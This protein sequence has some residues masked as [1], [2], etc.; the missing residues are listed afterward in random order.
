MMQNVIAPIN[1]ERMADIFTGA[2]DNAAA[3]R[4]LNWYVEEQMA[5]A[6]KDGL[7]GTDAFLHSL[8]RILLATASAMSVASPAVKHSLPFAA[9]Y[10]QQNVDMI[11]SVWEHVRKQRIIAYNTVRFSDEEAE[12]MLVGIAAFVAQCAV[13]VRERTK[14]AA[15]DSTPKAWVVPA[16]A[17]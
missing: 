14:P 17:I 13:I 5:E 7:P 1:G 4:R 2:V 10:E 12:K 15:S 6:T 8:T 11:E 9:N 16:G 3:L